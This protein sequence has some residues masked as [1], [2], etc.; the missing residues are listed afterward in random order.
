MTVQKMARR[1]A[2]AD[3]PPSTP[4]KFSHVVLRTANPPAMM[5]WYCKALNAWVV[6]E[7][8]GG[9]GYGLTFDE[10]HHRIAII[11][12]GPREVEAENQ[13]EF[14]DKINK[15]RSLSGLEHLSYTFDGIGKW[16]GNYTRLKTLGILPT[17]CINHGGVLSTYYLDPDGNSVELQTDTMPMDQAF[18][19]MYSVAFADN[20][21]GA[22]FDPDELCEMYETGVPLHEI[23]KF[24]WEGASFAP[25]PEDLAVQPQLLNAAE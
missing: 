12:M 21:I 23:A 15:R 20:S 17:L 22:P 13:L 24:G 1:V 18:E 14:F 16:L 9:H 25:R 5:D 11:G 8:E 10:E 2:L 4:S 6:F 7:G 19:F 3:M